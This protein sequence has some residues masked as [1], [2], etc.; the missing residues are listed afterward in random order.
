MA[1]TYLHGDGTYQKFGTA[2]G[3]SGAAGE[4]STLAGRRQIEVVIND[5]TT[6]TT[7]ATI[8]DDNTWLPKSV[9]IEQ[10]D[11]IADT[12]ATSAGAATLTIGLVQEDRSTAVDATGLVN[13]LAK[14]AYDADGETNI[15]T[16]GVSGAGTA[17]GTTLSASYPKSYITA[18]YTT[19]AFT[20][21]KLTIRIHYAVIPT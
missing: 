1:N 8:V 21:G 11:V 14:T 4:Y 20:A 17:V 2:E 15:L 12:A 5:L 16:A 19:A 6:L 3:A 9:R 7:T 13:A 18:K 10:V